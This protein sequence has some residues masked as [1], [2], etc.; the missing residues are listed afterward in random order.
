MAQK[1]VTS[2][3]LKTQFTNY[4][5]KITE[6]FRKKADSYTKQEIDDLVAAV[7]G[8][9]REIVTELP[10]ENISESKI[11]FV[12]NETTGTNNRYDEYIYINGTFEKIGTTGSVSLDGYVKQAELDTALADYLKKTDVETENI[13]FSTYFTS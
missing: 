2:D 10:T 5:A 11:Y 4:S 7:Q 8:F 6:I 13:D 1:Y 12:P 9:S 3:Y